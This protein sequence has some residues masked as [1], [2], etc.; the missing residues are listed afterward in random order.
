MAKAHSMDVRE[1]V[2]DACE[3]GQAAAGVAA[4]FRISAPFIEKL[5]RQRRERDALAPK[6]HAGGRRPLLVEHDEALRC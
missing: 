4:R 5:K 6:P 3:D 1:R 2:I